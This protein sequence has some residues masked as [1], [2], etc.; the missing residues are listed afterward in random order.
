MTA[1]EA[2]GDGR[3]GGL[4]LSFVG[5]IAQLLQQQFDPAQWHSASR[6][7][8]ALVEQLEAIDY[9]GY[10]YC[11]DNRETGCRWDANDDF[12][13]RSTAVLPQVKKFCHSIEGMTVNPG[14]PSQC[15]LSLDAICGYAKTQG[16]ANCLECFAR[17]D[18]RL[19]ELGCERDDAIEFCGF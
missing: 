13:D 12:R 3:D 7:C 2:E 1:E 10:Y 11:R 9:S 8:L 16:V 15:R 17:N 19:K 14:V 18:A 4:L 5:G 6:A